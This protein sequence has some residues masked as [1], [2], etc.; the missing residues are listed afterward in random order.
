MQIQPFFHRPTGTLSY[1]ISSNRQA[2]VIDPVLDYSDGVI[3]QDHLQQIIQAV[4]SQNLNVRYILETHIHADHLSGAKALQA[5]VGGQVGISERI[6]DVYHQWKDECKHKSIMP[7]DLLLNENMT[8]ELGNKKIE[9]I[10]TPGHTPTDITYKVGNNIFVGD[11][12]FSPQRGT[13]RADFPEGS[14][15]LQYHSIM[16]LFGLADDTKV[17]LCHDYPN[18][19]DKPEI[20]STIR[21]QKSENVMLNS[22]ISESDYIQARTKR[23]ESLSTPKLLHIALPFNLTGSI[24]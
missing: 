21:E 22:H 11:T 9:I 10:E 6:T 13:G 19:N 3:T 12:L 23:D 4:K 8:L 20:Y 15:E 5:E 24:C 17:Y 2:A 14:A 18:E 16:A 1:I 7:F